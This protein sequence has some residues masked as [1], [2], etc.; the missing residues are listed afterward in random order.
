MPPRTKTVPIKAEARKKDIVAMLLNMPVPTVS[1]IAAATG[2]NKGDVSRQ[3]RELNDRWK[4]LNAE[5]VHAHKV[6]SLERLIGNWHEAH[7]AWEKSKADFREVTRERGMGPM[8]P[9]DKRSVK[10][11]EQYG[12]PRFIA[13]MTRIEEKIIHIL[14]LE[15]PKKSELHI[16]VDFAAEITRKVITAMIPFIPMDR[17][18]DALD[19]A[20][21]S[22][23]EWIKA[24]RVA[25]KGSQ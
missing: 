11:R 6:A 4:E 5:G 15:A 12:D 1:G 20:T 23:D 18:R 14:G 25:A 13:E 19:M 7:E 3:L 8:G 21:Q 2:I 24:E 17:R 22:R 10:R 16:K 9:I